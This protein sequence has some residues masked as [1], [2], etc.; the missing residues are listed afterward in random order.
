MAGVENKNCQLLTHLIFV[1]SIKGRCC[2]SDERS[3]EPKRSCVR[4]E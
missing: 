1:G 2:G 4:K 3:F